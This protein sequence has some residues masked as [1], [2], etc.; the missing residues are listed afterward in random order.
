MGPV[1]NPAAAPPQAAEE[2]GLGR[3]PKR[4][5]G[6]RPSGVWGGAPAWFEAK[7]QRGLGHMSK[8]I[9]KMKGRREISY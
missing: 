4:G 2:R 8:I 7:P 5:L 6:R 3:E 1:P 9:G